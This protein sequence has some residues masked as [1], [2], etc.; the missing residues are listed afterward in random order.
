MAVKNGFSKSIEDLQPTVKAKW[1]ELIKA[2]KTTAECK[3]YGVPSI[4]MTLRTVD[5]QLALI[6]QGEKPLNVVNALRK[7]AG[8]T[9]LLL[10]ENKTKISWIKPENVANAPHCKG[11]AVDFFLDSNGDGKVDSKDWNEDD[12]FIAFGKFAK[13]KGWI[14]GGNV[15]YG[16]DFQNQNDLP[17]IQWGK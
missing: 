15:K 3:K 7:K 9:P 14:W 8:L 11:I 16:G 5:C 4:T 2:W 6:A 13:S 1:L 17:H 12:G 10:A